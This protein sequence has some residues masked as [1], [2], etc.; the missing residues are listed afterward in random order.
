MLKYETGKPRNN[1]FWVLEQQQQQI[2]DVN[3]IHVFA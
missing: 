3:S 1:K 2:G